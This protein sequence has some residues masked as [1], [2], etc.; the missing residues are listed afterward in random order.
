MGLETG[1]YISDLVATN[2]TS[3]DPKSQGDDHLRLIKSTVKATFPNVSNAVT[4]THTELNYVDGVT[5]AIQT[6]LDAKAPLSSPTL[7]GTPSAPTADVGTTGAQI[8]TLDFV[9]AT[10]LAGTLPGQTG[11]ASKFL[12]TDGVNASWSASLDTTVIL[13]ASGTKIATTTATESLSNKSL[14]TPVIQDSSDT[15]K[16]ANFILSG[17][18]AGQNRNIT[19]ADENMTLFTPVARLLST[20]TASNSATVDIE[21]TF[22]TTYDEYIIVVNHLNIQTTSTD[23]RLRMKIGGSYLTAGYRFRTPSG[24]LNSAQ[25]SVEVLSSLSTTSDNE[26]HLFVR[27]TNPEDTS[28]RHTVYID[29]Y[30]CNSCDVPNPVGQQSS[31]LGALTGIRFLMS[32]GNITTG[33]FK[34][35]GIRKT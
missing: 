18:T 4:P 23:L 3:S 1:T 6:Q 13:P 17:V 8:A 9:I 35:F 2:P 19:I 20:V 24:T 15:T 25:S 29:G 30:D 28:R 14:T 22:D 21:T 33:T 31:T 11:N 16:K 32:S 7:T 5:S 34:L 10:S 26:I 12:S 27:L